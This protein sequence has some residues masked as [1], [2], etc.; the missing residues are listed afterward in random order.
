M[1]TD[2][3]VGVLDGYKV[4]DFTQYVA[5]PTVTLMMAE[6]GAEVIK[7]ELAPGGDKTRLAPMLLNGRSGYY[8]QHNRGKKSLCVDPKAPDGL[9]ILKALVAKVDVVVENFAPGVIGRMGLGWETVK[10]IN[11]RAV[12]CSVSAFGQTGPLA[13]QP[14]FDTLGAAYAGITS[15]GGAPDGPPYVVMAAIGDVSTGAHA[16][17]AIACALLYRERS[18][19]GQYLDLSLLDTYFHY[20]EASVQIHSLSKGAY[21]PT[22]SGLHNFYLAPV[23]VFKAQKGY[24]IIMCPM[25][26]IFA[27]LCKAMGRPELAQDSRFIDNDSRVKN[28]PALVREIENWIAALPSDAAALAAMREHRVPCAPVLSVEEAVHHPH[29]RERGTIRTVRDRILGELELPGFALRF[30]DFPAPLDLEAPLLGEHNAEV[31]SRH[32]GYTAERIAELERR[33]V[34]RSDPH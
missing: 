30:S 17:G 33:G 16:M 32:L 29:L 15:M 26:H 24:I 34:I 18:G 6:M 11:P 20:H 3:P 25:D 2:A 28:C 7:V 1:N 19:R 21:K 22:R 10:S 27:L 14:G 12:M 4:L 5:G 31:L 23:G 9:A 8:V 13:A